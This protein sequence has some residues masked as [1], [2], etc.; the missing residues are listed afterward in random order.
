MG[1]V[2]P[3][4]SVAAIQGGRQ[5]M[6]ALRVPSAL[7]GCSLH[8]RVTAKVRS[9]LSFVVFI[10]ITTNYFSV[11]QVGCSQCADGTGACIACKTGFTQDP[12]D[13]TLCD[14]VPAVT[15]TGTACPE[16]SFSDGSKCSP[17]S[18]TCKTCNGG[19]SNDCIICAVGQYLLNG[20]CVGTNSDGVCQGSNLI[21]DNIKHEC[22]S[23]FSL[24]LGEQ[25]HDLNRTFLYSL[26][27]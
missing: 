16:G 15:T 24:N 20:N 10:Q 21:A 7:R 8:L 14:P 1:N 2:T 9:I 23:E 4:A 25:T 27:S 13:K 17:C 5:E 22:D 3:T 19:T 26:R 6:T 18:P 11:C 12:N